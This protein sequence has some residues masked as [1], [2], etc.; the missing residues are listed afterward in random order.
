[1]ETMYLPSFYHVFEY[2]TKNYILNVGDALHL[3][4][5]KI[6]VDLW[7]YVRGSGAKAHAEAYI[8]L[9]EARLLFWDLAHR[10]LYRNKRD[11]F[12]AIGGG[13]IKAEDGQQRTFTSRVL[14]IETSGEGD[15]ARVAFR[16]QN[17]V[18]FKKPNGLIVP[19]WWGKDDVDPDAEVTV[20]LPW[21]AARSLGLAVYDHIQAWENTTY[22]IRVRSGSWSP[23]RTIR[24]E[25]AAS[26]TD[27]GNS[28]H[29]DTVPAHAR[30]SDFHREANAADVS[31]EEKERIRQRAGDPAAALAALR[32]HIAERK[33][34]A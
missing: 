21:P 2:A 19:A 26:S 1:M 17:G 25:A 15:R 4:R 5:P 6:H 29:G 34:V 13:R 10:R 28:H 32:R 31:Y 22:W 9:H 33:H 11:R 20:L 8:D 27:T 12:E 30:W 23:D 14:S 3:D 7:E 18:G 24:D 16:A